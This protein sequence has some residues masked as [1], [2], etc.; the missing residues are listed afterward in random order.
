M[1][2][3]SLPKTSRRRFLKASA[4]AAA[5]FTL[6]F[7]LP[8]KVFAQMAGPGQGGAR[9]V[10]AGAWQPNAFV[11]VAGD[12]TV[13]VL[14]KHL[15][16]GQGTFTGLPTV[17]A[18]ELDADWSQ[19][20][21]EGAPADASRYNNLFLGTMQGTGGSTALANSYEQM[22]RAGAAARAMLLAAAAERWNV[23]P[24]SITIARGAVVHL[25]SNRKATFGQLAVAAAKLPVP[26][27]VKLKDPKD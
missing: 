3:S 22:R 15:E 16:M 25:P 14:V 27:D 20:R 1:P 26:Q 2:D 23:A 5:G 19:I 13:T 9:A 4:S 6:S 21:V 10:P 17:V 7:C 18:E 11:R 12:N 24:D 8:G